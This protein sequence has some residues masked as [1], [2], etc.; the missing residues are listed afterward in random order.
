MNR[1]PLILGIIVLFTGVFLLAFYAL[2]EFYI[3]RSPE[4][5][6]QSLITH[7]HSLL[8]V[9]GVAGI[10]SGLF[11]ISSFIFEK[12]KENKKIQDSN[13]EP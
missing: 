1:K 3:L 8:A 9:G 11:F 10:A 7:N 6:K 13:D 12:G 5:A 2:L 4:D